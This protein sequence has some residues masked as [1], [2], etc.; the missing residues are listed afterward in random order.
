M[1]LAW[2]SDL[3]LELVDDE[4]RQAFV[5]QT[6]TLP[7]DAFLIGGDIGTARNVVALLGRME[8]HWQRPIYFVLGNHDFYLGSIREVRRAVGE[9][10]QKRPRLVY[11][12]QIDYVLLNDRTILIGHDGWADGREGNYQASDVM[13]YAYQLITE[14]APYSKTKRRKKLEEL[15]E[16]TVEHLKRVFP[17]AFRRAEYVY[18]LTHIPPW[19]E[20]CWY[21]GQISGDEWAPHFTC[22]AVGEVLRSLFDSHPDKRLTVLCGHTHNEGYARIA[23]NIEAFIA[24]ACNGQPAV[25]RIL[26]IPD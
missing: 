4:A 5:E 20:A 26:E 7:V 9:L 1:R 16:E 22:R 2:L 14:L 3:H 18:F 24:G 19:R 8:E 13:Q 11:L 25:Y 17:L 21:R 6:A 12:S 23:P 10:C 15:A